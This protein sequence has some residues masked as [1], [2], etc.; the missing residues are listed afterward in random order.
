MTAPIVTTGTAELP[1]PG[2]PGSGTDGCEDTDW[3]GK[4]LT[5]KIALVQRGTCPFVDKIALAESLGAA[6]VLVFN[7]GG[8]DRRSRCRSE[9]TRS[10]HP[11]ARW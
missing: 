2:G 9:R 5:G 10:R 6:A 1:P 8:P 4:D 3:A 11:G 7:D